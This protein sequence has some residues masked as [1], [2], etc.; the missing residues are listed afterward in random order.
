VGILAPFSKFRSGRAPECLVGAELAEGDEVYVVLPYPFYE[1]ILLIRLRVSFIALT[2][3][4]P[5]WSY[6]RLLETCLCAVPTT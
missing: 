1:L 2:H 4:T 5:S 3:S 6:K